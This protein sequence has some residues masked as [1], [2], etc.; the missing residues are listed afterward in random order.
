MAGNFKNIVKD[1]NFFWAGK[2]LKIGVLMV[3]PKV[4]K[5]SEINAMDL[6]FLTSCGTK[7]AICDPI[8]VNQKN[9]R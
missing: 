2:S 5:L 8:R 1:S 4:L 9:I 3:Q 7:V 6:H